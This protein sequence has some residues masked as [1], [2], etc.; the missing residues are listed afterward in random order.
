MELEVV[1]SGPLATVQDLGRPGHAALGVGTSGA[2]DRHALRL[3]NRL[4]GNPEGAAAIEIT[5]GGFA[6]RFDGLARVALAGAPCAGAAM[7]APV[8]LRPGE[9][10]RPATPT[11]QVLSAI[12]AGYQN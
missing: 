4:V 12:Q 5:L 2:A 9:A 1:R 10:L 8:Y 11:D 7:H 6:A 3:A